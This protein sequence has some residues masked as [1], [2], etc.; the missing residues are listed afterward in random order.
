[1]IDYIVERKTCDD[2]VHSIKDG[3]YYNQQYRMMNCGL[4]NRIYLIE[5]PTSSQN[6]THADMIQSSIISSMVIKK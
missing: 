4:R 1:M 6:P 3:R 2:L 5:G